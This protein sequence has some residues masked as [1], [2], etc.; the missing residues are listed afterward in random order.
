[1]V[2]EVDKIDVCYGDVKVLKDVSL[3]VEKGET[4]ALVGSNGAGK[5]TVL[6]TICGLIRP[7]AGNIQFNGVSLIRQPAYNIVAMGIC[8]VPEE[9]KVF[10]EMTVFENLEMGAFLGRARQAKAAT[11]SWVY[12]IFPRLQERKRQKAGT[13]SGGEQ[14]MLLVARAL[15]TQPK[16]L[17]LDEIS[18]G[19]SPILV[20]N[21]FRTIRDIRAST[22]M[23]ILLVE[24]NVRMALEIADRAY[25][26]ENGTMVAEGNAKDFLDSE[27][28]R[29]AYF[30]I[31]P[32]ECESA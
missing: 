17:L 25:I 22:G 24:Q 4:V 15:M 11:L 10:R 7:A 12:D 13:L 32:E 19:L 23:T 2:L 9:K 28:V 26:L 8:M 3:T 1:M 27:Q 6:K 29:D 16:L 31:T 30:G 5:S 21:L 18:F 20:Q 14:Q